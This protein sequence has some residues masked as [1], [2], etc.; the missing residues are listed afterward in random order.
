MRN[1]A[2]ERV[3]EPSMIGTEPALARHHDD[4]VAP[5]HLISG[6]EGVDRSLVSRMVLAVLLATSAVLIPGEAARILE[7]PR[8]WSDVWPMLTRRR[9]RFAI[10]QLRL[11]PGSRRDSR[12]PSEH[13]A[14]A[15]HGPALASPAQYPP[16][17]AEAAF[18][19]HL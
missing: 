19:S 16:L 5:V 9:S 13:D 15:A 1:I 18:S 17:H 6:E 12:Q 3:D 7:R 14:R 8:T 11:H 10:D 4:L 2:N